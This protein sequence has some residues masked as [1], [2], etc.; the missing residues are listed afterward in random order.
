VETFGFVGLGDEGL[1]VVE[2]NHLEHVT[3][4]RCAMREALVKR[5]GF[6]MITLASHRDLPAHSAASI[7]Q[8]IG[9]KNRRVFRRP[10]HR[11]FGVLKMVDER[12]DPHESTGPLL[13]KLLKDPLDV[14]DLEQA[15][16][17]CGPR[18]SAFGA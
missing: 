9:S 17:R 3:G 10:L 6:D 14:S 4:L 8:L 5:A 16:S 18:C 15:Q 7:D 13:E 12:G 2:K 11:G 1:A